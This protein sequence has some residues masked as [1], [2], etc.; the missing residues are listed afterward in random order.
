MVVRHYLSMAANLPSGM[1]AHE[2]PCVVRL[3][4]GQDGVGMPDGGNLSEGLTRPTGLSLWL[5]DRG[6]KARVVCHSS[7]SFPVEVEL[8][9]EECNPR[10]SRERGISG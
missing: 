4:D 3:T 1:V 6:R 10:P 9:N 7:A 8:G 5:A 2:Q